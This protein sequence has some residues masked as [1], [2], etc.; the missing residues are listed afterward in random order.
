[1]GIIEFL[2]SHNSKGNSKYIQNFT[3]VITPFL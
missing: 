3:N 2:L 1:M